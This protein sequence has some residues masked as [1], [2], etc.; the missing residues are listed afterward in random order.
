MRLSETLSQAHGSQNIIQSF[1]IG[2]IFILTH[3]TKHSLYG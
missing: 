1:W 3:V 2:N